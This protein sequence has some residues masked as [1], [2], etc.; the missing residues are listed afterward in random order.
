MLMAMLKNLLIGQ[1]DAI[2]GNNVKF[3]GQ[4]V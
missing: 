1:A 3:T 2:S 4:D